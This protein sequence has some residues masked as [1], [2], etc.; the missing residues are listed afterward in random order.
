MNEWMPKKAPSDMETHSVRYVCWYRLRKGDFVWSGADWTRYSLGACLYY[1]LEAAK[2]AA[3]RIPR[4]A[5]FRPFGAMR[6]SR[7]G[8]PYLERVT[9]KAVGASVY[10]LDGAIPG[11]K[12]CDID[13]SL[14]LGHCS[15]LPLKA[16]GGAR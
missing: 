10:A 4:N 5:K 16:K 12:Q 7:K 11:K 3:R 1:S 8:D 15:F 13:A 9:V 14:V 6:L 2:K